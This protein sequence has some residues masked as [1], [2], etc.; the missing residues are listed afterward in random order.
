MSKKTKNYEEGT[1]NAPIKDQTENALEELSKAAIP[2]SGDSKDHIWSASRA[3]IVSDAYESRV[4]KRGLQDIMRYVKTAATSGQYE[5]TVYSD[6][7]DNC[8]KIDD[9]IHNLTNRG[10]TVNRFEQDSGW[11]IKISW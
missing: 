1:D 10:Y 5:C 11:Y 9:I 6:N 7:I 3:R 4:F 8:V 2:T